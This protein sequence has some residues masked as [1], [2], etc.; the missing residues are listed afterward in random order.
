MSK[1]DLFCIFNSVL[2]Y[3]SDTGVLTW[4]PRPDEM[5]SSPAHAKRWNSS[6]AG[7]EAGTK[8]K[9]GYL[10]FGYGGK[11]HKAHRVAWILFYGKSPSGQIDHIN[12]NRA[13]NRI[14]N[15][16][17]A[18]PLMNMKNRSTNKN[19]RS[20]HRGVYWNKRESKWRAHIKDDKKNLHLGYFDNFQDAVNAR[21]AAEIKLGFHEN[22]GRLKEHC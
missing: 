1:D 2:A 12:G 5:F 15:L 8:T 3:N 9:I 4:K 21:I 6:Y 10:T 19:C 17:E 14:S 20:G 13:D 16:R 7:K 11:L 18:T 22:H